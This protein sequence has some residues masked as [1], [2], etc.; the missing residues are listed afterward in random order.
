MRTVVARAAGVVAAVLLASAVVPAAAEGGEFT[1][2][3]APKDKSHPHFGEGSPVAFVLDGVQGKEL[4]LVRGRT[5]TFHVDTGAMHDFYFSSDARGTG[6]GTVTEGVVGNFT[7][8][9]EVTFKPGDATPDLVYYACRNHRFMGGTIHVVNAGEEGKVQ[10]SHS[11]AVPAKATDHLQLDA[12]ELKQRLYFVDLYVNRSE[13]AKRVAAAGS[14]EQ[15]ARHKSLQDELAAAQSA[16]A[17]GDLPGAKS[18]AEAAMAGM[19]E[20]AKSLPSDTA[21]KQAQQRNAE[22][23]LG[24]ANLESS[25]KRNREALA[26]DPAVSKLPPLD[27]AALHRRVDAAK[28]QADKGRWDEAN[29]QLDAATRELSAAL[30][31]LLANKT[32]SYEVKFASEAEEYDYEVARYA[33][34]EGLIPVAKEKVQ[35]PPELNVRLEETL[36][37]GRDLRTQADAAARAKDYA[38]ALE[39]IRQATDQVKSALL[40]LGVG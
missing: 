39:R 10:L 19:K 31:A 30:N 28:V 17:G 24:I 6:I 36:G 5:Y 14:A 29:A 4:V 3:A 33:S 1:V 20:L 2:V 15:K 11:T 8:K 22:L 18:R 35:V 38:A 13:S 27:A 37:R 16:F 34:Y 32:I 12:G 9:G 25:Y 23:V 26:G 40:L 7:Y 21:Q